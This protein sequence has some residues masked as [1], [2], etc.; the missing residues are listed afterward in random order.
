MN[1]LST[2]INGKSNINVKSNTN[3]YNRRTNLFITKYVFGLIILVII[4][5]LLY[6]YNPLG[7][8]SRYVGPTVF[9]SI[10]L[11]MFLIVMMVYNDYLSN[12][13]S[14][15]DVPQYFT[16]N[17]LI[18]SISFLVSSG[19]I[20]LLLWL[21]GM[22][23]S[24]Q[25]PHGIISFLINFFILF[26][27]LALIYKIFTLTKLSKNSVVKAIVQTVF[28]LP[29]LFVNLIEMILKEY[30][31][32]TK[33]M[34]VLLIMVILLWVVYFMYP[35]IVKKIY[36]QGG[37]QLVDKPRSLN[38]ANTIGTY[39]SLN[40]T[41]NFKYQYALSF[42]FYL[43]AEP[44]STN[45]SYT[46]YTNIINYGNNPI[47]EYNPQHNSLQVTVES[48]ASDMTGHVNTN[49]QRVIYHKK[50]VLLQ[51]WNNM[52]LNYAGGTLDIF[53]NGE[54][55]KSA[56]EVVPYLTYDTLTIGANNGLIGNI[57]NVTYFKQPLTIFQIKNL[58]GSMKDKNPPVIG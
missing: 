18:V 13:P 31:Q 48:N 51:K 6:V 11:A 4:L 16:W 36:T 15:N 50:H 42:W 22:F 53:Y 7:L 26:A 14:A 56:I 12:H 23:S 47:V 29:C 5:I 8:F 3:I 35:G 25:T 44:P 52:I 28:Y 24:N 27:M 34:V 10:A 2:N 30:H 9:I 32:T 37:N 54:L 21:L 49:G 41:D 40:G 1:S 45:T 38:S 19:L 55:V 58:Y 20:I 17:F 33:S 46:N 57:S 39:Q 43:D